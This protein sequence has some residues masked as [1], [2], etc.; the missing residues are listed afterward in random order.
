MDQP[1]ANYLGGRIARW[2]LLQDGLPDSGLHLSRLPSEP[3]P[4]A[5]GAA[6]SGGSFQRGAP[7]APK[8][9]AAGADDGGPAA[10][11]LGKDPEAALHAARPAAAPTG[12]SGSGLGGSS[13]PAGGATVEL[14]GREWRPTYAEPVPAPV[15][16]GFGTQ[17]HRVRHPPLPGAGGGAPG[18]GAGAWR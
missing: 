5:G 12:L 11:A 1:I 13:E 16:G 9:G 17:Y 8:A 6:G 10:A 18:A 15:G 4:A 14:A 7:H 2:K 3:P